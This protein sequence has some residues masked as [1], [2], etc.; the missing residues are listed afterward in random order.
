MK[1][2]SSRPKAYGMATE[3]CATVTIVRDIFDQIPTGT[4]PIK[5]TV[6]PTI[7]FIHRGVPHAHQSERCVASD[8]SSLSIEDLLTTQYRK[9]VA[10]SMMN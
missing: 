9:T 8:K 2:S 10:F 3:V 6:I 7:P 5:A 4:L 1:K